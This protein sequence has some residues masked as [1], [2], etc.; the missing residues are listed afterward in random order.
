MLNNK[1]TP[2]SIPL[3]PDELLTDEEKI[4]ITND[5]CKKNNTS[6][7]EVW[8]LPKLKTELIAIEC[9]KA[10]AKAQLLK[11]HQS[12]AAE[13]K[14]LK[15]QLESCVNTLKERDNQLEKAETRIKELEKKEVWLTEHCNKID[16]QLKERIKELEDEDNLIRNQKI[17]INECGKTLTEQEKEIA[18]LKVDIEELNILAKTNND[19]Y[20]AK[21]SE[22]LERLGNP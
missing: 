5:V 7:D 2:A 12:E 9:Y 22:L 1:T 17:I 10:V 4:N 3:P 15:S 8:E 21:I 11:C 20:S 18:E 6:W 14:E 16:E 13:I 19:A